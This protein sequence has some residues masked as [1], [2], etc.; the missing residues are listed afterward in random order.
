MVR[1]YVKFIF[2][3]TAVEFIFR[4]CFV[5]IKLINVNRTNRYLAEKKYWNGQEYFKRIDN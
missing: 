5:I 3:S 4:S 2:Y 1:V